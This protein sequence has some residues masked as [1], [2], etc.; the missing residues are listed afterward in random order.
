[1]K[2]KRPSDKSEV[3]SI[4]GKKSYN[5]D[6]SGKNISGSDSRRKQDTKINKK[7]GKPR[8]TQNRSHKNKPYEPVGPKFPSVLE[9]LISQFITEKTGKPYQDQIFL[10]RLRQAIVAQKAAYW[11]EKPGKSVK[12]GRGYDI[13]AYL[14]YQ[15][16]VYFTQ[17]R[18]LLQNLKPESILPHDVVALDIGTGPGVVPLAII[19]IWKD[20]KK[21]YLDIYAIERS[22]E[23]IEAYNYL[24]REYTKDKPD[25]RIH[26]VIHDDLTKISDASL[27]QLPEHVNLITF[28]NVLAELEHLSIPTRAA[29]VCSFT[30]RLTDDGLLIIVEPAEMRHATSLRLL[31]NELIKN[32]LNIYSPCAYLWGSGCD[33]SSC[34]TFKEEPPI[35]ATSLMTLLAG[36]EEA[37]RFI[38]TDR[39]Y[40]YAILTKKQIN[41]C[42]YRIPRKTRMVRLSHM[43]KNEG[44][45]ISVAGLRMSE[46]IGT[47]GM[48]IFKFCDG[49]CRE[50]AYLVLSARNRRPGH[51]ALFSAKYGDPLTITGV[52]VRRHKQHK[53]WNLV[54]NQDSRI[55]RPDTGGMIPRANTSEPDTYTDHED[56]FSPSNSHTNNSDDNFHPVEIITNRTV[57]SVDR[58]V[59]KE[60]KSKRSRNKKSGQ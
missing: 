49:T 22:V 37:Y 38:N 54:I 2:Q 35:Q 27:A 8:N 23:H 40:A 32:G 44:R 60:T 28:Q 41:A 46:D 36:E 5:K 4:Q 51:G 59:G 57:S 7:S 33:P 34:W 47:K 12:Y 29:I 1:M 10:D 21:G 52:Q 17:F 42:A 43:E 56:H 25:I 55:E 13:L 31:Q 19:D 20:L 45:S 48:H 30:K 15:V 24:T 50:P 58:G 26:D 18:S 9:D 14:A 3:K 16:P 11:R 39:K 6:S 53:A